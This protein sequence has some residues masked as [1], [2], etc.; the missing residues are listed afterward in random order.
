[1]AFLKFSVWVTVR[2]PSPSPR[3][4]TDGRSYTDV[5]TKFSWLDGLPIFLTHGA[6]LAR[7]ARWSSAIITSCP[8]NPEILNWTVLKLKKNSYADNTGLTDCYIINNNNNNNADADDD[9]DDD[10]GGDDGGDGDGDDNNN[11]FSIYIALYHN[12]GS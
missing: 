6:S 1:M 2:R 4:C 3:V 11:N 10:D 8:I 7:F 12:E 9:D 5:I